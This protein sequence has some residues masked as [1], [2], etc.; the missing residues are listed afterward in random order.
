MV[1][2]FERCTCGRLNKFLMRRIEVIEAIE[3]HEVKIR[4][5]VWLGIWFGIG[6]ILAG[7]AIFLVTWFFMILMLAIGFSMF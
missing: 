2:K 5:P 1:S 4:N 3:T 7:I 6:L